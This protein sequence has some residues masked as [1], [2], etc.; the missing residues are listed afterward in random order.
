M[1]NLLRRLLI[2]LALLAGAS[3]PAAAAPPSTAPLPA[4][5]MQELA[6]LSLSPPQKIVLMGILLDAQSSSQQLRA[7]QQALAAD[8]VTQMTDQSADLHAL[9][10]A[11][12]AL[13]D[14]RIAALRTLRDELL[15]FYDGLSVEQQADVQGWLAMQLQR[16]LDLRT[17]I[18]LIRD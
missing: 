6:K 2:P 3:L 17:A 12:E 1:Q 16:L 8:A 10:A 4:Q 5:A 11:Q 13:T 9:V 18:E 14:A 7:K 15:D